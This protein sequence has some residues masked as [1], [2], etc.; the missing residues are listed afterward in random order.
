[1]NK[2][3]NSWFAMYNNY[4]E[5]NDLLTDKQYAYLKGKSTTIVAENIVDSIITSIEDRYKYVEIFCDLTK[6]FDVSKIYWYK[7]EICMVLLESEHNT[8][9]YNFCT[10]TMKQIPIWYKFKLGSIQSEVIRMLYVHCPFL[11][12]TWYCDRRT[13]Y[14]FT[15]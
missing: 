9:Y 7:N 14:T 5:T 11:F 10:S 3:L 1:M 4:F 15:R 8:A 2:Q 6:A 13:L 12:P